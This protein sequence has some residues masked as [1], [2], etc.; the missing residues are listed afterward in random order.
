[1]QNIL[2]SGIGHVFA[3]PSWQDDRLKPNR[4]TGHERNN[5]GFLV[6]EINH[7]HVHP[8]KRSNA[9]MEPSSHRGRSPDASKNLE[10]P[11]RI[12][13]WDFGQHRDL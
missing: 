4:D 8:F 7:W 10:D 9:L 13:Q 1:M 12:S 11:H 2:C 6:L 5:Y 3:M